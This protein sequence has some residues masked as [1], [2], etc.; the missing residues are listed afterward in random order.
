MKRR[1]PRKKFYWEIS[2]NLGFE[3]LPQMLETLSKWGW[4]QKRVARLL[5]TKVSALSYFL[6]REEIYIRWGQTPSRDTMLYQASLISEQTKI[7]GSTI[8]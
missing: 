4:S 3:T 1:R 7:G 6:A 2:Y 5:G 8:E